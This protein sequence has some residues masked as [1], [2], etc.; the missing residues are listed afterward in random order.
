MK[1]TARLDHPRRIRLKDHDPRETDGLTR[2]KAAKEVGK[3]GAEMADLMEMLYAAAESSLLIVLQGLDTSGKDG[4]IRHL[5]NYVNVQSCRVV[6]FKVPTST[7]LS[8]DFLWRVHAVTPAVREIAIFNRSH[9]EDVLAARVRELV[10]KPVWERRYDEIN[11]F[12]SL[13]ANSGTLILKFF[14]HISK[15]E[16]EERL[17]AREQE[18]EKSWKLNVGDWQDREHW[19]DFTR[20]YEDALGRCSAAHAPW[21]IV[22]ADRKWF[23]DYVVVKAI[24]ETLR[25]LRGGWMRKLREQGR[26]QEKLLAAYRREQAARAKPR[27]D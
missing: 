22:P 21:I 10:P 11:Q 7:E 25:P 2:E 12:E 5:L 4:T 26:V 16:Q 27:K 23:R 3:F 13:L 17:L 6:P 19:E 14:L 15:K 8:H 18:S 24:V 9:Y 20:A 1:D